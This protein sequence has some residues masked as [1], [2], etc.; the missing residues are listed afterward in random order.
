MLQILI[1]E[2]IGSVGHDIIQMDGS[3]WAIQF[4]HPCNVFWIRRT[5]E[6]ATNTFRS[7]SSESVGM[8]W[9]DVGSKFVSLSESG[10]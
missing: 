10:T 4:L 3:P 9:R 5:I 7:V 8:A 1:R 6:P 2:R